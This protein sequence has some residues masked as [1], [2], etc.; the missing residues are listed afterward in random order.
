MNLQVEGWNF[1]RDGRFSE[2]AMRR[3][4]EGLG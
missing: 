4:L 2:L 1:E 3:K